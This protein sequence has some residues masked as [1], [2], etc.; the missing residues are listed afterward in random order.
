MTTGK[1]LS[2]IVFLLYLLCI[3]LGSHW[4]WQQSYQ[5]RQEHNQAQLTRFSGQLTS[6]LEKYADI[7]RLLSKNNTLTDALLNPNN[8]AQLDVANRYLAEV[9]HI[10]QATDTYLL[11]ADGTTLAASNWNADAPFIGK[12][13]AFRP[14]FQQAIAGEHGRY[15]A[16]GSTSGLRGFYYA[17]PVIHAADTLGV[18]VVKKNLSDIE[19]NW[20][21]KDNYFLVTDSDGI[22]FMSSNPGWLFH[23]LTPLTADERQ[24]VTQSRRYLDQKI[25]SLGFTALPPGSS[26]EL[27]QAGGNWPGNRY[28]SAK[29]NLATHKLSIWVLSPEKPLFWAMLR[30]LLL[31]TLVFGFILAL[32]LLLH[33]RQLKQ[34]QL[35][36]LEA[37]NKKRLELQVMER[38]AELQVEIQEREKTE[39]TLRQTQDELIHAAKLAVL[40][41]MSASISHELNNPL[42][43][44]RSF[45]ENGKRFL[46]KGQPERTIDNLT[47]ITALTDRMAGISQQLKSFARKTTADELVATQVYPVIVSATE[48]VK[49]RLRSRQISLTTDIAA[50]PLT[51]RINPIQLEQVLINLLNNAMEAMD[52]TLAEKRI[53]LTLSAPDREHIEIKIED[54][55]IGLNRETNQLFEPFY[56]TKQN[57]LGLGLSISRQIMQSMHGQLLASDSPLG[58]ACFT[59]RLGRTLIKTEK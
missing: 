40:G 14:Y 34:Q 46:D 27:K 33:N 58:G 55:G 17:Y 32:L 30:F 5:T 19:A 53:L 44:I 38:T 9:N 11:G 12:N 37:E 21:E 25:D 18:I 24:R 50:Q 29:T 3:V 2:G 49:P 48:L 56:T 42:A 47:R 10:I 39:Q 15:F 52:N 57:G 31:I 20:R 6:Q 22:I 54:T 45:A 7:P 13:F 26:G 51:A 36:R 41:E 23:S 16:L 43:A 1:R 8:S 59:L 35:V 4:Q 28:L